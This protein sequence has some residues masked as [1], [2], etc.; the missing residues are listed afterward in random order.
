MK[1]VVNFSD[2]ESLPESMKL[3]LYAVTQYRFT[4]ITHDMLGAVTIYSKRKQ[5]IATRC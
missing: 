4:V 1:E 3:Y 2:T 5:V